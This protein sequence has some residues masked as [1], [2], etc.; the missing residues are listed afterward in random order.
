MDSNKRNTMNGSA[1]SRETCPK[2]NC[3][4]EVSVKIG[5]REGKSVEIKHC[6]NGHSAGTQTLDVDGS[7]YDAFQTILG[8]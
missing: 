1:R 7:T 3:D 5:K 8:P 4:A 2:E 6:A